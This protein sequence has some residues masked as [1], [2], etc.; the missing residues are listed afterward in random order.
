MPYTHAQLIAYH[1][2]TLAGTAT[3]NVGASPA[4]PGVN[5]PSGSPVNPMR[6]DLGTRLKRFY[7]VVDHAHTRFRGRLGQAT[8]LKVFMGPEF[9]FRPP[10][11]EGGRFRAYEFNDVIESISVLKMMFCEPRFSDWLIV[12][13]TI[14][15][16]LPAHR[17]GHAE[18]GGNTSGK[19][20]LNTTV[21]VKGG[22]NA[23]VH[24][25]HKQL[26]SQ[27]DGAP[28]ND[29]IIHNPNYRKHLADWSGKNVFK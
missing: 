29:A 3:G 27:I 7:Q 15:S 9:Y 4:P 11:N 28:S 13:G 2:P 10:P 16:G 20:F 12:A 26:I 19:A 1:V 8:T 23:T 6:A 17:I 22:P 14:F 25:Q 5:F 18:R 21:V 24:Y